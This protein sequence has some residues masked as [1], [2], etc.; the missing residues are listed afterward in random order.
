MV[1]DD[2]LTRVPVGFEHIQLSSTLPSNFATPVW[3][4]V[5][6]FHNR[7]EPKQQVFWWFSPKENHT[8]RSL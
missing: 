6:R 3:L 4:G 7:C 1:W 5:N 8:S 2:L